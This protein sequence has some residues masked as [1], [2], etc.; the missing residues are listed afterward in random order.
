MRQRHWDQLLKK[1][2]H[3]DKVTESTITLSEILALNLPFQAV[4][5]VSRR[6]AQEYE[7]ERRCKQKFKNIISFI[8][9]CFSISYLVCS[10][11]VL[12]SHL[13]F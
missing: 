13:V 8:C 4:V 10:Q 11:T 12:T 6:A 3:K 9:L 7:I 5:A 1:E 2:I